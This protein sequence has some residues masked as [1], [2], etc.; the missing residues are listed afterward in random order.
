[1]KSLKTWWAFL[2][3]IIADTAIYTSDDVVTG[4]EWF[5]IAAILSTAIG[6]YFVPNVKKGEN[7]QTLADEALSRRNNYGA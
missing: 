3:A 5:A 6:V 1:M 2:G 4:A 7:V